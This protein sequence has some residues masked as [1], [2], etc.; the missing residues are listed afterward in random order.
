MKRDNASASVKNKSEFSRFLKRLFR[1]KVVLVSA[2]GTLIFVLMAVFAPIIATHDPNAIGGVTEKLLHA[3]AQ[4]LL[5]T[6][7]LGRDLFSRIVYGARV[8]LLTGVIATLF[9]SAIGSLIG[10][11][12]AYFGGITDKLILGACETFN[13]IP[14][15]ALS[16]TLVAL[17]G[18][19]MMNMA[20]IL[21][22][23]MVPGVIR[24]M[25]AQAL[26]IMNNEY[27]L[28]AKLNGQ[29]KMGIMLKHVLPNSA[30]PIIVLSTQ[31]IGST[32]LMESG[33]SFLGIGITIPTASWGSIINEARA[34]LLTNP[35]YVL[36]PCVF[37]ALL[38]ICLNIL[39]DGVRDALDPSLRGEM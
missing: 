28:A 27:I 4:H 5:G 24:M 36:A 34:Y 31:S 33:L 30:S 26:S 18:G 12:A 15:I 25:R 38:I 37:L 29:A 14:M 23:G 17:L 32:I 7:Y 8:S 3:S 9:A 39:G 20:I 11:V 6:D 10:M 1:R 21:C 22:I 13:A 19:G 35:G 2:I 16:L